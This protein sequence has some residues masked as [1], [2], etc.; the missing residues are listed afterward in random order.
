[1][2]QNTVIGNWK[3]NLTLEEAEIF[4]LNFMSYDLPKRVK[5]GICV[6][7]THIYYLSENYNQVSLQIGAQ[8]CSQHKKGAFTGEVSAQMLASAGADM[9]I[10]GHSE[11][12]K[13]QSET[14]EELQQK[15]HRALD[16]DLDIIYCLGETL[17][18]REAGQLEAVLERQFAEGPGKLDE[19]VWEA[20]TLAYE[21]VWAI[22]TG[23]TATPEQ[24]EEV[25]AMIRQKLADRV[26]GHV[27][28][29]TTILYG[30]SCKPNNAQELFAQPNI[31]GGL[32]GGASLKAA[33]FLAIAES[34]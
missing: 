17:E 31:D 10:I 8:N 33:D 22:G 12:R 3:M 32:I 11:R 14:E 24:A 30:G 16:A 28:E 21:P 27:A 20:I 23:K 19:S 25:H 2:R 26:A 34:F 18:E 15:I 9:V 7:F 29:K 5:L 1:M 4:M 6:P 13:Y